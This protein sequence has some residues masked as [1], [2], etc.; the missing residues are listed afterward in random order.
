[1]GVEH[2]ARECGRHA[3]C[4]QF[5]KGGVIVPARSQIDRV[6]RRDRIDCAGTK[7]CSAHRLS[8]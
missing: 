4:Q 1:V 5:Q 6:H 3:F 8:N 7:L 2:D